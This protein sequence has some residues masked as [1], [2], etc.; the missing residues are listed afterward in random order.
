MTD[1][2][3]SRVRRLAATCLLAG[4]ALAGGSASAQ[5]PTITVQPAVPSDIPGGAPAA[6]LQAA[7]AFAWQEFI[8]LNWPAQPV[9]GVPNA[10]NRDT[11]DTNAK[12]GQGAAAST[13]T[14]PLVWQTYRHKVEILPGTTGVPSN[15]PTGAVPGQGPLNTQLPPGASLTAPDFGYNT[16]PQYNYAVY[17]DPNSN[18][19]PVVTGACQ[20]QSTGDPTSWINLDEESEIFL[21]H[22][23]AGAA[24]GQGQ[25]QQF[26]F[27][28][29]ANRNHYA[30]V[31]NPK[32]I[33][34]TQLIDGFWNHD[35][36]GDQTDN[37]LY[38]KALDNFTAYMNAVLAGNP[39]PLAQPAAQFPAGTIETKSAWRRLTQAELDSG[40]FHVNKVRFYE[41]LPMGPSGVQQYCWRQ[42]AWGLASLHIIQ[43]TP[44]APYF[45]YATFEQANT[46]ETASGQ[47]VEDADGNIIV[48]NPG[49]AFDLGNGQTLSVT[50]ATAENPNNEAYD[51][52]TANCQPG[53]RLYYQN[54]PSPTP[55]GTVC[56]NQR[57]HPIPS[58]VI[59]AN[60]AAHQAI[61]QYNSANG[62]TDSPW[63]YYKLVNVQ[64]KPVDKPPGV[65][66]DQALNGVLPSTYYQSNMLLETNYNLQFF[67]GRLVSEAP[68]YG[69]LM[70]DFNPIVPPATTGTPFKNT[71]FLESPSGVP[72]STYNMGGCMGCHGNAQVAGADF[73][74]ILNVGRNDA[75]EGLAPDGTQTT[76]QSLAAQKD[77]V[78]GLR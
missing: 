18:T 75:P 36:N 74:F 31:V 51:P 46:I 33:G 48:Q 62:I 65:I 28:A 20:G 34:G 1:I 10:Y 52:M 11:P 25:D 14:V 4:T 50:L 56:L 57:A 59:A 22:M 30:Y 17:A 49:P 9:T 24:P 15:Y 12:F 29:K 32:S 58:D 27:M 43:K 13:N 55:Q 78:E 70:S 38:N 41:L 5:A 8:A 77:K 16:Q 39:Q 35:F 67:S 68:S 7:A 72:V 73:S 53:S 42:E 76:A 66:L 64:Y 37:P 19:I 3:S 45:I 69:T 54:V 71:F 63:P 21:D 26:L 47:P 2:R 23:F 40:Q 6:D 60:K 44:S 61:A